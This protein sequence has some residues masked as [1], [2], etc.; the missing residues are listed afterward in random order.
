MG[1]TVPS[2]SDKQKHFMQAVAHSPE[3]ARK[4]GVS[5]SVGK[6]FEA[7]DK[8]KAKKVPLSQRMYGKAK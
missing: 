1:S 5:Q 4:V 3:F 8:A 2:V 6:D 7:A